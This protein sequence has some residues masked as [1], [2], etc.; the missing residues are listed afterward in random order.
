MSQGSQP[1][2]D[3]TLNFFPSNPK[4]I[5]LMGVCGTGMGAMAGLLKKAGYTISGS[6]AHVYPPMSEYL[7]AAGVAVQDGYR[8]ENLQPRP[9]LVVVGNVIRRDNPEALELARLNIPYVSFPQA[10]GEKFLA[11]KT[12]LVV[13]GTHGKTTTSS[14]LATM[15]AGAGLDPGFMIGGIVTAF[16]A[17]FHLGQGKYFVVEGDE[18]DTAFFD[19]GPKFLHYQPQIAILTSVEFDHADIYADFEAVKTS[20]AR[21]IAIMPAEGTLIACF[22]DP[23]VRELCA[24]APCKVVSYGIDH[25]WDWSFA[26]MVPSEGFTQF[27]LLRKNQVAGQFKSIMPGRHNVL[28]SLAVLAVFAEIG[29]GYEVMARELA[30]FQGVRRRQEVRG[31]EAGVTV[32]DDFAHHPTAVDE[33]LAAL[34]GA[35]PGRRLVA[36]FE[37]RTNS[38]RRTIFQE[39]YAEVFTSADEVVI[40]EPDPLLGVAPA[41]HFSAG[42]LAAD[43]VGRGQQAAS[44]KNTEL[45]LAHLL[46]TLHSGD[47][48]AILS[49]GGFDNIHQRLL[50]ALAAR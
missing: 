1:L 31:V 21:L 22:D 39:R 17:N 25:A 18:Y 45:I 34:K 20:F 23:V 12:S 40:K 38:S 7:A 33:T 5:H 13:A 37:P 50:A 16:Q 46:A 36:V 14:L 29:L 3:P 44:F 24:A 41:D 10:L 26:D 30:A 49:N 19:K 35:Y 28:N 42:L 4:H 11:G 2:L 9:D 48:V 32:I 47:V 6:D 27:S 43:L 8:P 15:L